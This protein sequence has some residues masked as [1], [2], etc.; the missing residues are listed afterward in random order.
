MM[1]KKKTRSGRARHLMLDQDAK[2]MRKT[3][4]ENKMYAYIKCFKCEDMKHFASGCP[5]KLKKKDQAIH[6]R[7]DNEK[8]H[9]SKE[10]KAQSKRVCYSC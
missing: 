9:M 7:Q 1:K 3:Q 5:T 2:M 4:D 10:E 6:K 8:Q